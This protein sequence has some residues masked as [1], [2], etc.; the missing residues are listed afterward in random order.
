MEQIHSQDHRYVEGCLVGKIGYKKTKKKNCGF[1]LCHK[2][3][4]MSGIIFIVFFLPFDS[5]RPLLNKATSKCPFVW[6]GTVSI[7]SCVLYVS[8]DH[9]FWRNIDR[10]WC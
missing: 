4:E 7:F 10:E 5:L 6:G 2:F 1:E 3:S 8:Y 9:V